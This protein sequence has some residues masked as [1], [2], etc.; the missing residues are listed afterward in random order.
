MKI[1]SLTALA[2]LFLG[3]STVLDLLVSYFF[4]HPL[5]SIL[6][7]KPHIAYFAGNS[8]GLMPLAAEDAV[9]ERMREWADLGVEAW[10]DSGWLEAAHDLLGAV[11]AP[12]RVD[13]NG[14]RHRRSTRRR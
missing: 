4:M 14:D 10:F 7:R 2:A 12:H 9:A 3:I 13:G 1:P 5:V 11:V 6:A 8:L